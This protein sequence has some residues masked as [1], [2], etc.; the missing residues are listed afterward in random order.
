MPVKVKICGVRRLHD[1]QVAAAAG[2]DYIGIVFVPSRRRRIDPAA[3]RV[4]TDG[5]RAAAPSPPQSVGL[6]GDQPLREALD[7]IAVAGLDFAQ[8]CG[9]EPIAYCRQIQQRAGVIKVLHVPD[10]TDAVSIA[11]IARR[12]DAYAAAGC[13]ITLDSQ[14]AGLHGGTGHSFDWSI[15]AD[16]AETGRSFLLAGGLTPD[17]V[18]AAIAQ[19]H[20]WGVDVSGGVETNGEK[21]PTKIRQFIAN[22]RNHQPSGHAHHPHLP[23]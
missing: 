8:L 13:A 3:A 6:F 21:D 22:A 4:I 7:T 10:N 23:E 14:V 12:I 19:V 2:A 1:A 11:G 17:N 5:L 20:P 16:L 9:E 15:A 18:A